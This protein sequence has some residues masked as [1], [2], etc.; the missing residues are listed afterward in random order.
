MRLLVCGSRDYYDINRLTEIL[1]QIREKR[2]I[3]VLINGM[4]RGAD[5]MGRQ[6]A[7]DRGIP[8]EDYAVDVRIDGPWPAAGIRRN[9][10]MGTSSKPDGAVAFFGPNYTGTGT[11]QMVNWLK[12]HSIP[13]AE[14]RT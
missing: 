3:D 13:V 14:I 5:K 4:A 7:L 12:E 10:R 1:C 9:I 11:T 6:W 2:G 8:T